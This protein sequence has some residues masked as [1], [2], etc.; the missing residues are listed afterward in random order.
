MAE[1]FIDM[2]MTKPNVLMLKSRRQCVDFETIQQLIVIARTTRCIQIK[3]KLYEYS[4]RVYLIALKKSWSLN[5]NFFFENWDKYLLVSLN[6][7][8]HLLVQS[9]DHPSLIKELSLAQSKWLLWH[10][11][12]HS[13]M[14][15]NACKFH[16]LV[17]VSFI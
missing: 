7:R 6:N 17:R 9:K 2:F 14:A 8:I 15:Y 16:P 4:N 11:Q 1:D 3:A 12:C 13:C 5:I 10:L